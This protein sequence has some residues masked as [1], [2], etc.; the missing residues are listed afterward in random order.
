M[1]LNLGSAYAGARQLGGKKAGLEIGKSVDSLSDYNAQ[2][3]KTKATLQDL[4]DTEYEKAFPDPNKLNAIERQMADLNDA[5]EK[6]GELIQKKI[7]LGKLSNKDDKE[8]IEN[9]RKLNREIKDL[10]EEIQE[11]SEKQKALATV[12][13]KVSSTL[14]GMFGAGAMGVAFWNM[15]RDTLKL[16]SAMLEYGDSLD[17]LNKENGIF[18]NGLVNLGYE[19]R[20]VGVAMDSAKYMVP[21]E[22]AQQG[23]DTFIKYKNELGL[24]GN[25]MKDQVANAQKLGPEIAGL[26]KILRQDMGSTLDFITNSNQRYGTSLSDARSEL[27]MMALA[28]ENANNEFNKQ[29]IRQEDVSSAVFEMSKQYKGFG[30][31]SGFAATM[32]ARMGSKMRDL[33]MAAGRTRDVMEGVAGVVT[34]EKLEDWQKFQIGEQMFKGISSKEGID[35]FINTLDIHDKKRVKRL[36]QSAETL[37][38]T[39]GYGTAMFKKAMFEQISATDKGAE[40]SIGYLKEMAKNQGTRHLLIEKMGVDFLTALDEGTISTNSIKEALGVVKKARDKADPADQMLDALSRWEKGSALSKMSTVLGIIKSNLGMFIGGALTGLTSLNAT[41][42]TTAV[43]TTKMAFGQAASNI[44]GIAGKVGAVGGV[45]GKGG[46]VVGSLAAGFAIGE[47]IN[48]MLGQDTAT[49]TISSNVAANS[50]NKKVAKGVSGGFL[51]KALNAGFSES[52]A[53]EM[54]KIVEVYVKS[55]GRK[56]EKEYKS[57]MKKYA[58]RMKAKRA[59]VSSGSA[60]ASSVTAVSSAK[61]ISVQEKAMEDRSRQ[62]L[63]KT[64]VGDSKART[65]A[66]VASSPAGSVGGEM[67]TSGG[68]VYLKIKNAELLVSQANSKNVNMDS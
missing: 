18:K 13:Q 37:G 43:N 61:A 3:E 17:S 7:Q 25:E 66:R 52:E 55:G 39:Y 47:G 42:L 54:A 19:L 8:S 27:G 10:S 29:K 4:M 59:T 36:K 32:L 31:D 60:A 14:R 22:A 53:E 12:G 46:A 23:I 40:A 41:S 62:V 58:D 21:V 24:V 33:G 30:F 6:Y 9:K 56:K 34:G 50:R 20:Q 44:A 68:D 1:A 15:T 16:R 57:V 63:S 28:V 35:N 45:A 38:K 2:L 5:Q 48:K 49:E 26:S 64:S 11:L 67:I 65:T 51:G